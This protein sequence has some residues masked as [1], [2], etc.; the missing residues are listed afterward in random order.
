MAAAASYAELLALIDELKQREHLLEAELVQTSASHDDVLEELEAA[1]KYHAPLVRDARRMPRVSKR[2]QRFAVERYKKAQAV[3][4][5]YAAQL[6]RVAR[7]VG[8][9]ISGFAPKGIVKAP[10]SL[11]K[12]LN[13]Y[14]ELLTPWAEAVS[15]TMIA[16]VSQKNV[17]AWEAH[18]AEMGRALR[19]EIRLTPVGR[20]M[21]RLLDENVSLIK[22]LPTKAGARVHKL[23]VEALSQTSARADEIAKEIMRSGPVTESRAKL[24]ARTEVARTASLLTQS[25]AQHVGSDTYV[26]RTVGDEDV[27]LD[28]RKLEGKVIRWAAPPVAGSGKGGVPVHY[29]A[30][31]GPNCRCYPEP[32]LPKVIL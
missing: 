25:R 13:A 10:A 15:E 14:S 26:W 11:T 19:Q 29:H 30:G 28:H 17:I 22:S 23:T 8:E 7:H 20:E 27:R 9:I 31:Q 6:R 2:E 18:G 4:R 3:E 12:V 24:I 16:R 21:R 1:Q 5:S 32:I